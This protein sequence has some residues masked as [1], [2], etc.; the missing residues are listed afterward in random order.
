MSPG[1]SHSTYHFFKDLERLINLTDAIFAFAITLMVLELT[2]PEV[3]GNAV[4]TELST[5]LISEWPTFL[6]YIISFIIISEWWMAHHHIFQHIKKI[7]RTIIILNFL[8]LFFITLIPFHTSLIIRYPEA[9]V[10]VIFY[11]MTQALAGL[12][13]CLLWWY[14]TKDRRFSES[15]LSQGIVDYRLTRLVLGSGVFFVSIGIAIINTYLAEL[16]WVVIGILL[17]LVS[18]WF[19]RKEL[20]VS[21]TIE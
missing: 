4:A 11:A 21:D 14:A 10:A 15:D 8:F 17:W 6:I 13:L 3:T 20:P 1:T 18:R 12:I 19:Y 2:V 7:D 5:P 9:P 16:S